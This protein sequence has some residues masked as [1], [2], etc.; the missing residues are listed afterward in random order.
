MSDAMLLI[1]MHDLIEKMGA[2][3]LRDWQSRFC[4]G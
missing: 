4:H 2:F 3:T 1:P